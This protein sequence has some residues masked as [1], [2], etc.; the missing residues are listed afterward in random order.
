M[1]GHLGWSIGPSQ[2][3][4]DATVPFKLVSHAA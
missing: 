3:L 4:L 1:E 2:S